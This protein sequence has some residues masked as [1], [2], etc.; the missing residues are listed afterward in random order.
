MDA[1]RL[2]F[3]TSNT[4]V[5]IY[6]GSKRITDT[7]SEDLFTDWENSLSEIG[8]GSRNSTMSHIAGKL[9]KR[10]GAK[11][12]TY[13]LFLEQAENCNPPLPDEE[14]KTIWNSAVNF[15]K[16]VKQQEDYIPPEQYNKD[17][18]LEPTDYSDVGQ[19]TVLAR[20][21]ACKLRYS[22]STDY[23][24]YNGSYWEES[25]P[26]SQA[27]AQALTERQLEEA[28]T[29]ITKQTQEMVKNGAFAIL[30]SVGPKKAV[31]MFNKVQAHS[32]E[33]SSFN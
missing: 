24:V 21:Y 1:A 31:T 25:A 19:A 8:E 5:E 17:T 11:K 26:K 4:D 7:L 30:A 13:D 33:L 14:L 10:Y 29:A 22:P 3:G 18:E 16:K 12:E 15:G 9:I 28:E 6:E 2:L 32:Y 23:I 20:E 27:V